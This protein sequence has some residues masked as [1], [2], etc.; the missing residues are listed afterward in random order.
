MTDANPDYLHGNQT[1][2]NARK[3]IDA[4]EAR[5]AATPD[6]PSLLSHRDL[7]ERVEEAIRVCRQ[8]SNAASN[9]GA[10]ALAG[11]ILKILEGE[12]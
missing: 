1:A 12:K 7:V 11:K 9:I 4:Y 6:D 10:H 8:H 3:A 2:V 5:K